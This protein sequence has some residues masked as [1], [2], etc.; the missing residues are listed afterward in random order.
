MGYFA[1]LKALFDQR[2][3][4]IG[5]F[6]RPD[7]GTELYHFIGKDIAYFHLLFWPAML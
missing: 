4:D 7:G 5:P 3:A 1:S 2:G 6:L